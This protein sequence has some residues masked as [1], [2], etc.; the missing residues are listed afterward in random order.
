[1]SMYENE[2][3]QGWR[4]LTF[5]LSLAGAVLSKGPIGYLL[6]TLV[7]VTYLAVQRQLSRLYDL[8]SLPGLVLAIG[9]PL[10]WYVLAFKQGGWD[11]VQK[12]VLQENVLRFTAGSGKRIPSAGFFFL[13][14]LREGFPWS[15]LFGLGVWQFSRHAP[16]RE[17]GVFPLL[18]VFAIVSFFSI[19]AGKR[20]VYLLPTYPAMVLFAAEWGWSRAPTQ[21]R[22]LPAILRVSLRVM[23][24]GVSL[25]LL[26]GALLVALGWVTV[27]S[28]WLDRLLGQK[29]WDSVAPFMR[30]LAEQPLYGMFVIALLCTGGLGAIYAATAGR[31]RAALW[32]LLFCLLLSTIALYPFTRAY[33]K[34]FRALTGFAAAIKQTV[35]P[36]EPLLFYTPQPYS[37]EFDEFS[38]VYFYLDRNV[39][40]APCAEQRDLSR[41]EPGYYLLRSEFRSVVQATPN[42][43]VLLDSTD[44][45]GPDAQARLLLVRIVRGV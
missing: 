1:M 45:A 38:Q 30:L 9:I 20:D 5:Y 44:S 23:A 18:W 25:L 16:V 10:A 35:R 39:P 14:F 26:A 37:S 24:V 11:F 41:C 42:A 33:S 32:A 8:C 6:P 13:P 36:E 43:H 34:E 40:L 7:I 27:E 4:S 17:K 29:K 19:S 2:R 28:V 12:Q 22:P 21:A 15:V 3:W 31:W